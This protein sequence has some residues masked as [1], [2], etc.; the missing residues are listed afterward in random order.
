MWNARKDKLRE[1]FMTMPPRLRGEF[2]AFEP[3]KS[4]RCCMVFTFD[5]GPR[6]GAYENNIRRIISTH[7]KKV[8]TTASWDLENVK[9]AAA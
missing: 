7:C 6:K 9:V 5:Y 2:V 4:N 3:D 8:G 1:F